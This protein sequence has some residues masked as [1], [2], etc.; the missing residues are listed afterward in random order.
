M[1]DSTWPSS[2]VRI[3]FGPP[4]FR[5][6]P[7]SHWALRTSFW[8]EVRL[9][10][11]LAIWAIDAYPFTS[12]FL[13]HASRFLPEE[14]SDSARAR[15]TSISWIDWALRPSL[16]SFTETSATWKS[17]SA[18]R[19]SAWARSTLISCWRTSSS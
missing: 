4:T 10:S 5:K 8:A 16:Y 3:S 7:S 19:R 14:T 15:A 11:A 17:S 2:S 1:L 6:F 9:I 12:I 18:V 13:S